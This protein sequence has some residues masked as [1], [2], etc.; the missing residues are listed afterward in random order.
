MTKYEKGSFVVIPN[1]NH[2]KGKPSAM[3]SIY[4]WICEHADEN[5]VC[6]PTRKMLAQE[7]GVEIKTLDKYLKQLVEEGFIIQSQRKKENSRENTSNQYQLMILSEEVPPKTV[8]P[9]TKNG[10]TGTPKNGAETIT[11]INSNNLT[12]ITS[13]PGKEY[14]SIFWALYPSKKGKGAVEPKWYKL[15]TQTQE[16]IIE[17]LRERVNKDK[18]WSRGYI[19]NPLTFINQ[20]RWLDEY[21]N[22]QNESSHIIIKNT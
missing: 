2:L 15:S 16:E 17:H 12:E 10:A 9:S 21:E 6:F 7:A 11:N 14:F 18:Q 5:G 20:K 22:I 19:P 1:K 4:F 3:Q 13:N 8:Q